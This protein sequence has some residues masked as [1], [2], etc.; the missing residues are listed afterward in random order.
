MPTGPTL[1]SEVSTSSRNRTGLAPER[2]PISLDGVR[3]DLALESILGTVGQA[4]W[5]VVKSRNDHDERQENSW[6][7]HSL[8]LAEV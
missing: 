7:L 4:L 3:R 5:D 8:L 1:Q 6:L 2:E